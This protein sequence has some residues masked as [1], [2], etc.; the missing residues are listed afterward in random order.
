MAFGE[1]IPAGERDLHEKIARE[2]A[3]IQG[4]RARRG[5]PVERVTHVKQHVGVVGELRV[6]APPAA[7]HGV[8]TEGD[9]RWPVYV[10][11]SN[12]A[13]RRQP[14]GAPDARGFAVKLVGVPGTKLIEGLEHELTQD[15][16]FIDNPTI[17]FKGPEEFMTFLRAA[18][19]GPGKL[20]PRLIAGFGFGTAFSLLWGAVTAKKLTSFATHAFHTAAP[21]AFGSSAAKLALFPETEGGPAPRAKG[22]DYLRDDLLAR[23]RAGALEWSLR[24]TFFVDERTTPI[25][26]ASVEWS[27]PWT[28]LARLT[29][30]KQDPDSP[31]GREIETLVANLSFDP[32]HASEAHR[33][34]G[35]IMRARRAAY[36]P[37]VIG[38]KAAPEPKS[39]LALDASAR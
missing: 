15:F 22:G 19:D 5:G 20:L 13:G 24:A 35:A 8:F 11:F 30:P 14:D 2:I 31:R 1:S 33:P 7:R 37:S 38:R 4:E 18:K 27:G 9:R 26:D 23:L 25:E 34:L 32:W 16:L 3:E 6:T 28:E 21:I 39:V 12:G 10:R 36:A 17:P 29:L